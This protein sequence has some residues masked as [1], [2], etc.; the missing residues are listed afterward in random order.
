MAMEE[1]WYQLHFV[2]ISPVQIWSSYL[3][4]RTTVESKLLS[5]KLTLNLKTL[6]RKVLALFL[7]ERANIRRHL[8]NLSPTNLKN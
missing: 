5:M 8:Q 3:L 2:A 7:L 1:S 6:R 4:E